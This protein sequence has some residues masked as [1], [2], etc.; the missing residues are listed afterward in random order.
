[1]TIHKSREFD[2]MNFDLINDF[3][4]V[5]FNSDLRVFIVG[6]IVVN[7]ILKCFFVCLFYVQMLNCGIWLVLCS[8]LMAVNNTIIS[9]I[10]TSLMVIP[11]R[12][13]YQI[14]RFFFISINLFHFINFLFHFQFTRHKFL[15]TSLHSLHKQL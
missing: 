12:I 9:A 13:F 11:T 4:S 2:F 8:T 5:L 1:M 3:E 6:F 7:F 15:R 14:H 10:Y